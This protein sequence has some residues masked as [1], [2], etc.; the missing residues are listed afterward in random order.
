MR[1]LPLETEADV[2]K[3][4]AIY[5]AQKITAF[6]PTTAKPFVLGLPTGD[7]HQHIYINLFGCFHL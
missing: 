4:A 3:C 1:L 6:C 7:L 5:I 2:A